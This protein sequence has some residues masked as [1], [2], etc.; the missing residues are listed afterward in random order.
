MEEKFNQGEIVWTKLK[1]YP[2]WPA[3]I[4]DIY[5]SN[6]KKVYFVGYLCEKNGSPL[7]EK[8]IKKWNINYDLFKDGGKNIKNPN[9]NNDFI[10]AL[11]IANM[12]NEGKI[13]ERDHDS[14]LEKYQNN[15]ER[16]NLKNIESFFN[17]VIKEKDIKKK[18][19]SEKKPIK[20][21]R[22]IFKTKR[23]SKK[24]KKFFY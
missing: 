6:K 12:Y 3:L 24:K 8:N 13:N 5:F 2:W 11:K 15:K 22:K 4:K 19:D 23:F 9:K 17:Y 1:G 21:K 20:K 14:F 16:H 10:C 18:D 7:N